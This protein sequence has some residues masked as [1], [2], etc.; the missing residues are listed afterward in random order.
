MTSS[1]TPLSQHSEPPWYR[2]FWPWFLIILPGTV[3]IA[4]IATLWIA[5]EGADDLVV[6]DYYRDGL[7]INQ[8]LAQQQRAAELGLAATLTLAQN[9][10]M[11]ALS[12]PVDDQQLTLHVSHPMEADRDFE[13]TLQRIDAQVFSA[14]LATEL[15]GRWHWVLRSPAGGWRLDGELWGNGEQ[16]RP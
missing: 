7:A 15:H 13:L 9:G 10:L 3:V 6:D 16:R 14:P 8:E 12:T 5:M 1:L 2:Q 11:A 4:A